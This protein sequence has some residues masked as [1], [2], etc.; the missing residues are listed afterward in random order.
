[1]R[2]AADKEAMRALF[3]PKSIAL[4]G[5]SDKS[6]WSRSIFGNLKD[7]RFPGEVY[8]VNPRADEVHGVR[9]FPSL[10]DIGAP[11]DVVYV[12]V[13]TNAVLQVIKDGAALGIR[14]FV[15]LT[16]GFGET[17]PQGTRLEAEI[18]AFAQKHSLAILGPNTTGYVNGTAQITPYANPVPVPLVG[19]PVGLVLQ[20]GALAMG[21]LSFAQDH[22]IGISLMAAMGN[23]AVVTVTDVMDHL[24]DDPDTKVI[25]LFL[26]T[27]RDPERFAAAARRAAQAG[28][29]VVALKVGSSK[30]ASD[31]A[32]A[33][34]GALVGDDAVADAA[35]RKLGVLRVSSIE[36]LLSTAALMAA[37][38]PIRGP[39][40]A[41]VTPSGGASEIIADR[42]EKEGLE[43]VEFAP[44]TIARLETI[45]PEYVTVQNPLDVSG[46]VAVDPTLLGRA[47]ETASKDSN[48][49]AALT[50]VQMPKD[51]GQTMYVNLVEALADSLRQSTAQLP[52]VV[53]STVI[54][55]LTPFGRQ[56][57]DKGGFAY[58]TG[59]DHVMTALGNAVRWSQAISAGAGQPDTPAHT[60]DAPVVTGQRTGIWTEYQ[61]SRLLA[62][63][64]IPVVPAQ[65]AATENDAVAAADQFGYPVVLKAVADDLGHKS[66][67]G[68]VQLGLANAD[69]VRRAH[70]Q[71]N[72]ALLE[73]Q[74]TGLST[75]VQPQRGSGV[76]L[77]VGMIRDP[78]WGLILA[79]GL[80]GVW[81]EVLSDSALLL[82]PVREAD[83]R[84]ALGRLRGADLLTGARGTQP[85]DLDKLAEI[86]TRI[87]DLAQR[88]G[89]QLESLEINPLLVNGSQIEALDALITWR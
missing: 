28:K 79:V 27:V 49:D 83:V 38:G 22:N 39:R 84:H 58:I 67:F 63:N 3:T 36:D 19:G 30:L 21:L 72:E 88:L 33:H 37:V 2:P 12:M 1:M 69:D 85:A 44:A 87:A 7:H 43:L 23:E 40:L 57:V 15:V 66:D 76:E 29:P 80:G 5:A 73:R 13:P 31:T 42:A 62:D 46:F 6:G 35:F 25:A 45:V 10:A 81:V 68:G 26:E 60:V 48:F 86:V 65:L 89:P 16:A 55:D 54:G 50:L 53:T 82:P 56:L 17:G 70:R 78:A 74:H 71:I 61:A 59:V 64:G 20:S 51:A 47:L 32:L 34:T 8:L 41:V 24:V 52:T 18:R 11:V 14:S 9:A 75:L 4:V 77:I